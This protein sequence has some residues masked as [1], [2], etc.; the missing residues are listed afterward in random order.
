MPGFSQLITLRGILEN[1]MTELWIWFRNGYVGSSVLVILK[2]INRMFVFL[3][4]DRQWSRDRR[5]PLIK[6]PFNFSTSPTTWKHFAY[7]AT[8]AYYF[9]FNFLACWLISLS[10]Q[11]KGEVLHIRKN[12][13]L[14]LPIFWTCFCNDYIWM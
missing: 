9:F 1:W 4:Y 5:K 7:Y 10:K 13:A 3:L 8:V 2:Y 12:D 14:N 11:K 6:P